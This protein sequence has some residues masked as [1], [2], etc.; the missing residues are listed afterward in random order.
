MEDGAYVLLM[1][2]WIH[3]IY[4]NHRCHNV[5]VVKLVQMSRQLKNVAVLK[6]ELNPL[7]I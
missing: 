4:H 6:A 7:N 5:E 2:V 3:L 1:H